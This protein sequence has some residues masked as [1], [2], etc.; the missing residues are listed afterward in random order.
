MTAPV[1]LAL[2][3]AT[4]V[5]L[6]VDG[7]KDFCPVT[8]S[9]ALPSAAKVGR[10]K[11]FYAFAELLHDAIKEYSPDILAFE[12]PLN[13]G[14]KF[15]FARTEGFELAFGYAALIQAIAEQHDL[16]CVDY[17]VAQIRAHFL[18]RGRIPKGEGKK[19]VF[20]RCKLLGWDVKGYDE[21]D[22]AALWSLAKAK[23]NPAFGQAHTPLL[24]RAAA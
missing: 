24:G 12:T 22:S 15:G 1:V 16:Q 5:G 11:H 2:D 17:T 20:E 8:K 21:S 13:L 7:P 14:S 19:L 9:H 23:L 6:S 4:V 3:N 10:P 18:G